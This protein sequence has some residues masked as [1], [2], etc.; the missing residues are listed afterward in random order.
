MFLSSSRDGTLSLVD[1]VLAWEM[2]EKITHENGRFILLDWC[3]RM[4]T[5]V[6][7]K[8]ETVKVCGGSASS[9]LF[10]EE[11]GFLVNG[12]YAIMHN[13][14]G[15]QIHDIDDIPP[16]VSIPLAS[17][18]IADKEICELT[19]QGYTILDHKFPVEVMSE[20]RSLVL[21][22][23]STTGKDRVSNLVELSEKFMW[24]ATD[25][26]IMH[27][28]SQL[29]PS[30][31]LST[32]SSYTLMPGKEGIGWHV[33]YPYHE[34]VSSKTK[35][36]GVQV[37]V[38]LDAFT[39]ENGGTLVAP[40]SHVTPANHVAHIVGDVGSVFIGHA[41]LLHRAGKNET[42][43]PRS[44][45]LINYIPPIIRPKDCVGRDFDALPNEVRQ[46]NEAY[47]KLL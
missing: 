29:I 15:M 24:I 26:K 23:V 10:G 32:M 31:K 13:M 4:L 36:L 30:P 1:H 9:C 8:L 46:R 17:V 18:M 27:V 39:K 20:L 16:Y 22:K 3:G 42:S 35:C 40:A 37:I 44:A 38:M 14:H 41:N 5:F 2:F 43:F 34:D 21:N 45:I 6:D 25:T 28:V 11:D 7:K 33:D 19:C 47:A 12:E